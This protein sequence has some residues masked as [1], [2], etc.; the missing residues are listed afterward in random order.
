VT[1]SVSGSTSYVVAGEKP[2]GS[3]MKGATKHNIPVL[4]EPGLRALLQAT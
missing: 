2:G 3:K 4:D 1:D